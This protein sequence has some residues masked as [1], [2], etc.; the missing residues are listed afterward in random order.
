MHASRA[1]VQIFCTEHFKVE[2]Q[3]VG[4]KEIKSSY[5]ENGLGFMSFKSNPIFSSLNCQPLQGLSEKCFLF[6]LLRIFSGACVWKH[7]RKR[8]EN[9]V[10]PLKC[11]PLLNFPPQRTEPAP[12]SPRAATILFTPSSDLMGSQRL[13]R[14]VLIPTQPLITELHEERKQSFISSLIGH[15]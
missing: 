12:P 13:K 8:V 11:I 6:L 4:Q 7:F 1:L 10:S 2:T 14:R 5:G 9:T 3:W 15:L